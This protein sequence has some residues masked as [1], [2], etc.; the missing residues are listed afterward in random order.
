MKPTKN[1]ENRETTLKSHENQPRIMKNRE[2][3]TKNTET[4]L[5]N[6]ENQSSAMKKSKH[7]K[8]RLGPRVGHVT[9]F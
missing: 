3:T 2:T 9:F 8:G 5:K 4:N 6:H 1:H 7:L